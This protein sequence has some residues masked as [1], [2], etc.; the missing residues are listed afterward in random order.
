MKTG[1]AHGEGGGGV[2]SDV[3]GMRAR[4]GYGEGGGVVNSDGRQR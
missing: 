3:R 1:P 2:N 4:V